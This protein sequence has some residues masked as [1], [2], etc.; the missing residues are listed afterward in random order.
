M[1]LPKINI[2]KLIA[3]LHVIVLL[4]VLGAGRFALNVYRLSELHD[5]PDDHLL[6]VANNFIVRDDDLRYHYGMRLMSLNRYKE[7][8]EQMN[9][10]RPR[11]SDRMRLRD[12]YHAMLLGHMESQLVALFK[13]DELQF[14]SISPVVAT[15]ILSQVVTNETLEMND[16]LS[17]LL[18]RALNLS[19]QPTSTQ[20]LRSALYSNDFWESEVGQRIRELVTRE[21]LAS[22]ELQTSVLP[23]ATAKQLVKFR[24]LGAKVLEVSPDMLGPN[25][26]SN[27]DI[28]LV[29]VC[30]GPDY[31]ASCVAKDWRVGYMSDGN[32][33]NTGAYALTQDNKHVFSGR[34]ALR[35]DG[36]ITENLNEKEASRAGYWYRSVRIEPKHCVQISVA[37]MTRN[38]IEK[39]SIWLSDDATLLGA[40]EY[41]LPAGA[42][43]WRQVNITT[44]N[45]GNTFVDISPFLRLWGT[46]TVWFDDLEIY[47]TKLDPDRCQ[48][49]LLVL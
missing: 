42:M 11:I 33:W 20:Q 36:L 39:A 47:A 44:F 18:L 26:A 32:L 19:G 9:E 37:F 1:R 12:I 14:E 3:S 29:N 30:P 7:S 23:D 13:L 40:H 48:P 22:A 45:S 24:D 8:S 16:Q 15:A 49:G 28:E 17:Q 10:V 35:I 25:L 27:G 38:N 43:Q 46:G 21:T 31:T 5:S 34:R 4:V 6:E 2:T 41:F